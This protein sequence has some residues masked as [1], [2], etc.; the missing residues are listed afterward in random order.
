MKSLSSLDPC[1][2]QFCL[3]FLLLCILGVSADDLAAQEVSPDR[4]LTMTGDK[5]GRQPLAVPQAEQGGGI[6]RRLGP[7]LRHHQGADIVQHAA[8]AVGE[9]GPCVAPVTE[10]VIEER[11]AQLALG[12]QVAV[13]IP[14][15][16]HAH[17]REQTPKHHAD[18]EF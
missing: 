2:K 1:L 5:G 14:V 16:A 10:G 13:R 8:G 18:P 3:S 11:P 4:V 9:G 7:A 17:A 12:R 6:E 15:R